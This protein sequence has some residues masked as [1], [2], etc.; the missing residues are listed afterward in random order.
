MEASSQDVLKLS[1]QNIGAEVSARSTPFTYVFLIFLCVLIVLFFASIFISN[2][3]TWVL[4]AFLIYFV[5]YTTKTFENNPLKMTSETIRRE[6]QQLV[7]GHK[8]KPLSLDKNTALFFLN[9]T[10]K[11]IKELKTIKDIK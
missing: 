11:E 8:G 10:K 7:L 9:P 1:V 5:Y 6:I 2:I 4:I 3:I